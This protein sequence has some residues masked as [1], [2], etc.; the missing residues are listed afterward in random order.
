M[1]SKE[2]VVESPEG[3]HLRPATKICKETV[4]YDSK[5]T[6]RVHENEYNAKS[7]ISV[8]AAQVKQGETVTFFCDGQDE[9]KALEAIGEIMENDMKVLK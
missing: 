4:K 6:F 1:V 5:I 3:F 2:F 8:L 9:I 7:V